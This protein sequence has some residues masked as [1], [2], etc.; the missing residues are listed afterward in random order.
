MSYV[1]AAMVVIVMWYCGTLLRLIVVCLH[2]RHGQWQRRWAYSWT[3]GAVRRDGR[4]GRKATG[5]GISMVAR[6]AGS[7]SAAML[8][9]V[10]GGGWSSTGG[11]RRGTVWVAALGLVGVE[12]MN[13]G[14][15]H[16]LLFGLVGCSCC[17]V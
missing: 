11:G 3:D 13:G 14:A 17:R 8:A 6:G 4:R 9:V 16:V 2:V 5:T 12:K 15:H 7:A 10:R 1:I